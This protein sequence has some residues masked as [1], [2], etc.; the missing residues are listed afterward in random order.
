MLKRFC[1][2]VSAV[3]LA[4]ALLSASAQQPSQDFDGRVFEDVSGRGI[5]NL[6]VKLTPPASSRLPI[7]LANTDQNGQ[8]RF[9]QVKQ[10]GYM[11]EVSQGANLL[12]RRQI[13]TGQL[14]HIDIPLQKR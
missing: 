3:F 11:I 1:R 9:S 14:T 6:E 13:D 5:E 12:Y 8:F 4:C 10:S 7:R 2:F